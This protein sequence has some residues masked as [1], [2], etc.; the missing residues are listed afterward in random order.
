[1]TPPSLIPTVQAHSVNCVVARLETLIASK[2][3]MTAL[4]QS[5]FYTETGEFLLLAREAVT[6][7]KSN[8][9]AILR[10]FG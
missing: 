6:M 5:L 4:G 3:Q 7:T 10:R 8:Q 9:S 2:V 1:M